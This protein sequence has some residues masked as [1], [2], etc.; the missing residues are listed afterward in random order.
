MISVSLA[1][2]AAKAG[3]ASI[4]WI[5][6]LLLIVM[7]VWMFWQQSR[8]QKNRRQ[9]QNSI[10]KGD[11]VV[12]QGGIIGTVDDVRDNEV[13]LRIADG[14]KIKVLKSAVNGKHT[15]ASK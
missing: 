8:Q 12:T 4:Y 14:V 2:A 6:F 11:R 7:T 10:S 5:F 15:E 3:G 9:L 1:A 13:T